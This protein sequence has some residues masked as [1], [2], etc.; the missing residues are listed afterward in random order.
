SNAQRIVYVIDA[1]GGMIP[2]LP[3]IINELRKSLDRLT[4]EQSFAIV[5]YQGDDAILVPTGGQGLTD[6]LPEAKDRAL[7]WIDE[8][9]RPR[10]VSN[11]IPA[12]EAAMRLNPDVVF[13]LSA[14]IT[15]RGRYEVDQA[16]L[17]NRLDELNP[18]NPLDR[19]RKSQINCIQFLDP[20]PLDTM[21]LIAEEHGGERGYR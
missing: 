12:F 4:S 13:V 14:N 8:N 15:A 16:E 19:R 17:L 10:Q 7:R 1:S 5:F 21:R 9:I 11:P 2:Y 18:A 6:A 20:D 3:F